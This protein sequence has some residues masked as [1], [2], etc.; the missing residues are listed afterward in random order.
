MTITADSSNCFDDLDVPGSNSPSW[1]PHVAASSV[2]QRSS[3]MHVS[4]CLSGET[5]HDVEHEQLYA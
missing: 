4:A 5:L 3:I 1:F 2:M